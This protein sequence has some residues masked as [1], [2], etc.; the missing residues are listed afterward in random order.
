M[1]DK[2]YDCVG[3][4]AAIV[5]I[6]ARVDDAFLAEHNVPKSAMTLMEGE[7]AEAIHRAMAGA[8]EISGGSAANTI[9]GLS[10]LGAR[11]AF[12]GKIKD[13]AVGKIFADDMA[14]IGVD[15]ETPRFGEH[16]PGHTARSM[17]L[18]TP[19]AERSMCTDLG[20]SALLRESDLPRAALEDTRIVYLEG[21]LWDAVSTKRAFSTAMDIGGAAGAQIALTLSDTFCVDRHRDSFLELIHGPVDLLFANEFELLSLYETEDLDAAAQK[22]GQ[23]IGLAVVTRSEKGCIV[24]ANGERIDL[25]SERV[26]TLVDTTGAGDLFAAG[27]LYGLARG[28]DPETCGKMGNLAASEVIQHLGARPERDLKEIFAERDCL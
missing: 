19:D 21:Y 3:L 24:L 10:S 23:A 17:I 4:G 20:V 26:E 5:D 14:R 25:P 11:V 27:F 2:T 22:L 18:V 15:F 8:R 16:A 28:R 12:A 9:V 1:T 13:D 7:R 6:L